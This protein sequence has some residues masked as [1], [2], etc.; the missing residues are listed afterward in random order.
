MDNLNF[1]RLKNASFMPPS[2]FR[3]ITNGTTLIAE[4][5]DC[6]IVDDHFFYSEV[7]FKVGK[8][9]VLSIK[10]GDVVYCYKEEKEAYRQHI[11]QR[12]REKIEYANKKKAEEVRVFWERYKIPFKFTV[13]IKESLSGLGANSCGNG[14]KR[15][16]VTHLY[17][18]EFLCSPVK[19]KVG[20]DWSGT[21]GDG[22]IDIVTCKSCLKKMKKWEN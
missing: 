22:S 18:G 1:Y 2:V 9:I 14:R 8:D 13:E 10:N 21:L 4:R 16:T 15:N 17:S 12:E 5:E 3:K 20:G 19:S 11:L 7:P 6:I